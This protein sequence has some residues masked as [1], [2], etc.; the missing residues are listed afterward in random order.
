[1]DSVESESWAKINETGKR[2]HTTCRM[3]RVIGVEWAKQISIPK[4]VILARSSLFPCCFNV[5]DVELALG[6][7]TLYLLVAPFYRIIS[8]GSNS[9]WGWCYYM[10]AYTHKVNGFHEMTIM[11]CW[12]TIDEINMTFFRSWFFLSV[13]NKQQW[14]VGALW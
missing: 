6:Q 13:Q 8:S 2:K 9:A 10:N 14:S 1:M 12:W 4:L 5:D 7:N 3:L 11:I